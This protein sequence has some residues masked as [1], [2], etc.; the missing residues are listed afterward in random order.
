MG[1]AC[2]LVVV[3]VVLPPRGGMVDDE[4]IVIVVD[5]VNVVDVGTVNPTSTWPAVPTSVLSLPPRHPKVVV[6]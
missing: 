1:G 6:V 5:D 2:F 4:S 3:V